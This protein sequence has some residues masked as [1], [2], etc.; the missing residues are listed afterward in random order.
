MEIFEVIKGNKRKAFL[1]F[2][3]NTEGKFYLYLICR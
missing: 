1:D 2:L 3:I